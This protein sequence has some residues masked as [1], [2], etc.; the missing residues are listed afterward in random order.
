MT[1]KMQQPKSRKRKNL[2]SM[3]GGNHGEEKSEGQ[4]GHEKNR[5][6]SDEEKSDPQEEVVF[7]QSTQK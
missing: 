5:E 6:K 2:L 1:P 4:K 7:L 3:L